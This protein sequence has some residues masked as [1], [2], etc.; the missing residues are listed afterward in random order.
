MVAGYKAR[1]NSFVAGKPKVWSPKSLL[2]V[3]GTPPYD[4]SPDGKRFAVVLY[5]DGTA[6]QTAEPIT[7]VTVILNFYEEL[8]R[9]APAAS[10]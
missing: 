7:S 1:G 2:V 3:V 8:R 10:R 4:V 5:P 9:R 6:E